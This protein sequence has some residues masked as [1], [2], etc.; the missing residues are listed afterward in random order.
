MS[1]SL[2]RE[3]APYCGSGPEQAESTTQYSLHIEIQP[4]GNEIVLLPMDR[5]LADPPAGQRTSIPKQ[6]KRFK[7]L[8]ENHQVTM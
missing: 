8:G 1:A 2:R 4:I 3:N 6:F 7:Q 5:R